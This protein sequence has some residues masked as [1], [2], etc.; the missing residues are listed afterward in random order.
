MALNRS[1]AAA[2]AMTALAACATTTAE[3]SADSRNSA[4]VQATA[5]DARRSY[6]RTTDAILAADLDAVITRARGAGASAPSNAAVSA[7]LVMDELAAGRPSSARAQ[8]DTVPERYRSGASDLLEA[9]V[10]LGEGKGAEAAKRAKAAAPQ[11][12]G[13]LGGVLEALILEAQGDLP[14]AEAAYAR[15]EAQS[16]LTPPPE[17]EPASLEEAMAQLSGPQ[18]AQIVYRM[19]LVKHR[20]GKKEDARRFYGIVD[21]FAPN[22]PDVAVNLA[23]LDRG[24]APLEPAL[25]L[26]RGLGR[27]SLFLSEEFGRTEGLAQM[28]ADPTPQQGL[29]SPASA[30]FAQ[31]GIALDPSATDWMVGSAYTLLRA[32]GYEGA[33]RILKRIPQDSVYAPDAAIGLA[34]V[35]LERSDDGRAAS[36]AQRAVRLAPHRWTVALS[37]ASV[38]TRANKDAA[39]ISAYDDALARAP[40][41]SDRAD[42]LISRAAAHNYFGRVE[43]AV[44]DGRAAVAADDRSEIKIAAVGY[45]MEYP[46]GWAEAVRMGRELLAERPE[47]VSRLN[48]LGYTLIHRPEGLEEGFRLLSRGVALGENDYAVVDSLGWAYYLYGD[49]DTALSFIERSNELSP[50]PVAEIL[51]HLGDVQWRR[52]KQEEARTAWRQALDAKPEARRRVRLN[53]KLANGLTT[54]APERK[55]PPTLEPFTPGQRQDT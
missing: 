50:E 27:W 37:A 16:N 53:D 41:T 17:D 39:A 49:F 13:R 21:K 40:T 36:E 25:D 6:P 29:V 7:L 42:I 10:I 44:D 9:W 48:Q 33:E 14:A 55:R 11:L 5:V 20:L 30:L 52:G 19:A 23:R 18:T 15:V 8:L 1:V 51:D 45:L 38:L 35:A 34:E 32:D 28:L 12:P 54:P 22:S 43:R 3:R 2:L 24:E 47:S 31:M 26:S 46:D 4:Q